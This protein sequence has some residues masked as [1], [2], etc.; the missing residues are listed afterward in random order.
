MWRSKCGDESRIS[1]WP[2]R[3]CRGKLHVEKPLHASIPRLQIKEK[4]ERCGLHCGWSGRWFLAALMDFPRT[5]TLNGPV[6]TWQ[7]RNRRVRCRHFSSS[8]GCKCGSK[9]VYSE[10]LQYFPTCSLQCRRGVARLLT[11]AWR[12][13]FCI[14]ILHAQSEH[15]ASSL[16]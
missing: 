15:D 11:V 2:Q 16:M 4:F 5:V 7:P 14:G 12:K 9:C 10:S 8:H 1:S 3:M 13:R 6:Q